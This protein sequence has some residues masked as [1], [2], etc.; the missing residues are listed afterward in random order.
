MTLPTAI[1]FAPLSAA[2]ML[3][4]S[5][6]AL[7]PIATMV[8]PTTTDGMPSRRAAAHAP[9]TK[10]SAPQTSRANPSA[11]NTNDNMLLPPSSRP[12]R[13]CF[14]TPAS[15]KKETF[16]AGGGTLRPSN[17]S[18]ASFWSAAPGLSAVLTT[19]ANIPYGMHAT[20]P[21]MPLLYLLL[22]RLS[23]IRNRLFQFSRNA[24]IDTLSVP[25]RQ[26][27]YLPGNG[28]R[29]TAAPGS[30]YGSPAGTAPGPFGRR[31]NPPAVSAAGR[32][33][34]PLPCGAVSAFG[35]FPRFR[36]SGAGVPLRRGSPGFPASNN[37]LSPGSGTGLARN[38][39][40]RQC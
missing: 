38:S 10:R 36:C 4:D 34:T 8:S 28:Y 40:W 23:R 30:G 22:G 21:Y 27:S 33:G 29:R 11:N 15:K 9:S 32:C 2:V 26:V 17:K 18:L 6:G 20:P 12:V 39:P 19:A 14:F 25:S 7:V 31:C 5:S 37:P 3:T 13:A 16:L 35:A 1:S 24:R